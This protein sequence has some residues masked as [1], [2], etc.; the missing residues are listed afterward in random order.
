MTLHSYLNIFFILTTLTK[1]I[2]AIND[3]N[4][5]YNSNLPKDTIN[6]ILKSSSSNNNNNIYTISLIDK[7]TSSSISIQN[8]AITRSIDTNIQ[9]TIITESSQIIPQNTVITTSSIPIPI[10]SNFLV[11]QISN[12]IPAITSTTLPTHIIVSENT[13]ITTPTANTI[14]TSNTPQ[15]S[16]VINQLENQVIYSTIINPDTNS[17][18]TLPIDPNSITPT[19]DQN[20]PLITTTTNPLDNID[21]TLVTNGNFLVTTN[22]IPNTIQ[23]TFLNTIPVQSNK[24][25]TQQ[26]ISSITTTNNNI[27]IN[28]TTIISINSLSLTF[29]QIESLSAIEISNTNHDEIQI[30]ISTPATVS[31]LPLQTAS[32]I[33][34]I[35]QNSANSLSHLIPS[36]ISTIKAYNSKSLTLQETSII[37]ETHFPVISSSTPTT[38]ITQVQLI[39]SSASP[40][41]APSSSQASINDILPFTVSSSKPFILTDEIIPSSTNIIKASTTTLPLIQSESTTSTKDTLSIISRSLQITSSLTKD[42]QSFDYSTTLLTHNSL[43]STTEANS[44]FQHTFIASTSTQSVASPSNQFTAAVST[45]AT[46]TGTNSG[47]VS[48]SMEVQASEMEVTIQSIYSHTRSMATVAISKT[49]SS[50][51]ITLSSLS[52]STFAAENQYSKFSN[53]P[54]PSEEYEPSNGMVI[55][56]SFET[57][58]IH[59]TVIEST[60]IIS[61]GKSSFTSFTNILSDIVTEVSDTISLISLFQNSLSQSSYISFQ[62]KVQTSD[63]KY[64]SNVEDTI[65][66]NSINSNIESSIISYS[67]M[68]SNSNQSNIKQESFSTISSATVV[69]LPSTISTS[70]ISAVTST[71]SPSSSTTYTDVSKLS[72]SIKETT[73][74]SSM[75]STSNIDIASENSAKL[76]LSSSLESIASK[77]NEGSKSIKPTT[78]PSNNENNTEATLINTLTS[79]ASYSSISR[80]PSPANT[81]ESSYST[82]RSATTQVGSTSSSES[83][84]AI[85]TLSQANFTNSIVANQSVSSSLVDQ[86]PSEASQ[87]SEGWMPNQLVAQTANSQIIT[88]PSTTAVIPEIISGPNQTTPPENY[89]VVTIGFKEP[90]NYDF[91]LETP[92]AGA[93]IINYLPNALLS[94]IN[95]HDV[96]ISINALFPYKTKAGYSATIATVIFPENEKDKLKLMIHN[97]PDLAFLNCTTLEKSLVELIDPEI[98]LVTLNSRSLPKIEQ[99][100]TSKDSVTT[101]S[102]GTLG[103][104]YK[105]NVKQVM[106]KK[107]SLTNSQKSGLIIGVILGGLFGLVGTIIATTYFNQRYIQKYHK[108]IADIESFESCKPLEEKKTPMFPS[109]YQSVQSFDSQINSWMDNSYFGTN[110]SSASL[111]SSSR[112][113]SRI[114]I[115]FPIASENSLG[116]NYI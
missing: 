42:I 22:S 57:S 87:L 101:N 73:Q 35:I 14:L 45:S 2:L 47:T 38:I 15:V 76:E 61:A 54:T 78:I 58:E 74:K 98:S 108:N 52:D 37:D 50:N 77:S 82:L 46:P 13:D 27:L 26:I 103:N 104:F 62:N 106:N 59:T 102:I 19:Q 34:P 75:L 17:I 11:S 96:N 6:S 84:L 99:V 79:Q 93:Q 64:L 56:S 12:P 32:T 4:I 113:S 83:Y 8:T 97:K 68:S 60:P 95:K 80:A 70:V 9:N 55:S 100:D 40:N 63:S 81:V 18:Q 23:S 112:D 53:K 30:S 67:M 111:L 105:A 1:L 48:N 115:S 116:W 94:L 10:Q 88:Q 51:T 28:P 36:E 49:S 66:T 44:S 31:P 43:S 29:E 25:T 39:P 90:L 107:S 65:T 114:L 41:L 33:A 20:V 92:I 21:D 85:N 3:T 69:K 91:V 109:E 71:V 24:P 5:Y 110:N 72:S 86:I 89:T 16:Q 7:K